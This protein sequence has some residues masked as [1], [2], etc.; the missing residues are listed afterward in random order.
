MMP[1]RIVLG[2]F[3]N[4]LESLVNF[5]S[6]SRRKALTSIYL[7]GDFQP[8]HEGVGLHR[9]LK[10]TGI[11]PRELDGAFM[12]IGP[13]PAILPPRMRQHLFD[14]DGAIAAFRIE[15]GVASLS[16]K[17]VETEKLIAE[18][19]GKRTLAFGAVKGGVGLF[20]L[21]VYSLRGV[22]GINNFDVSAA[23]TSI[24]F[25]AR[26]LL[27]L[28]EGSMPYA[29]RVL[30]NGMMETIGRVL[31]DGKYDG[32]MSAHPKVHPNGNAYY[33]SYSF[34]SNRSPCTVQVVDSKGD[35][36]RSYPVKV[37]RKTF[38]HDMQ[39]TNKYIVVLELALVFNPENMV[40]N[41]GGPI[42]FAKDSYTRFG[43]IPIDAH[44]DSEIRWFRLEESFHMF[45]T[46]AAYEDGDEVVVWGCMM[47]EIDLSL[48]EDS[49]YT[50]S[51]LGRIIIN[52]S[53]GKVTRDLFKV[54]GLPKDGQESA[55]I[56]EFPTINP[57]KTGVGARYTY[58]V[59]FEK[60][61]TP[62]NET[63]A[64]GVVKFDMMKCREVGTIRFQSSSDRNEVHGGEC[65]FV[66]R[67]GA[68]EEDDGWLVTLTVVYGENVPDKS[69]GESSELRV[70]NAKTMDSEPVAIIHSPIRMPLG[71]HSA[72][73]SME[74]LRETLIDA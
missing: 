67:E 54:N 9:D 62:G 38:M 37:S 51:F 45:H 42:V 71:F 29:V 23:N 56:A 70:Y 50:E 31:F 21:I 58:I 11:I 57:S 53:T 26:K 5:I 7:R 22:L 3:L 1:V 59:C 63:S 68:V 65:V 69:C 2:T 8:Q 74:S 19:Q 28:H 72:F 36:I 34:Y 13:N 44:D 39:I 55:N 47:E 52:T 12:Q 35:M 41:G 33:V 48:E 32:S 14:G 10:V 40:K 20:Y 4:V 46:A 24:L 60:S 49:D 27:A 16:W 6:G 61:Q 64:T 17:W 25:H 73:V 15:K 30:C 66:A 43:L 18:R